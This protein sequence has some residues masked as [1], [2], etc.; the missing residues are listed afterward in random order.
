MLRQGREGSNQGRR[1]KEAGRKQPPG[2][3][4]RGSAQRAGVSLLLLAGSWRGRGGA[5]WPDR[6]RARGGAA[7]KQLM[8]DRPRASE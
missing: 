7:P 1:P 6:Q 5:G 3:A 2:A 8:A 4:G